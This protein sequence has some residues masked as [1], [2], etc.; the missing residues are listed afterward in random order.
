MSL[1]YTV[2]VPTLL[3][4]S[5]LY[6]LYKE[7]KR[8]TIAGAL[9]GAIFLTMAVLIYFR[10]PTGL[11]FDYD[12]YVILNVDRNSTAREVKTA[13][14]RLTPVM[15][16][17]IIYLLTTRHPDVRHDVDPEVAKADWIKIQR[18]QEM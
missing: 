10:E 9:I 5:Q 13:Y 12:P 6:T 17:L 16:V 8:P 7:I 14:R 11:N 1:K 15:Y 4:F 3:V 18:S 2:A